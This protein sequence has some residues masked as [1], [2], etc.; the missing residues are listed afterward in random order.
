MSVMS[1]DSVKYCCDI[2]SYIFAQLNVANITSGDL[3]DIVL[4]FQKLLL[5]KIPMFIS[6]QERLAVFSIIYNLHI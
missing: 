1:F 2:Y 6:V 4:H 5:C 3:V